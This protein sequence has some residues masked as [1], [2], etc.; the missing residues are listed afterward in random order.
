MGTTEGSSFYF[1]VDGDVDLVFKRGR[2]I[3]HMFCVKLATRQIL[4]DASY[5]MMCVQGCKRD[6]HNAAAYV[7]S[8]AMSKYGGKKFEKTIYLP[9]TITEDIIESVERNSTAAIV[10]GRGNDVFLIRGNEISVNTAMTML[11]E[12]VSEAKS[13]KDTQKP[14]KANKASR[15]LSTALNETLNKSHT[16][17]NFDNVSDAVKRA[18]A[19]CIMENKI[20]E[21][22]DEKDS[23]DKKK[24]DEKPDYI[25]IED[26][27]FEDKNGVIVI[28]DDDS[29]LMI[30]ETPRKSK[31]KSTDEKDDQVFFGETFESQVN[32]NDIETLTDAFGELKTPSKIGKSRA[33][34]RAA[35]DKPT[36]CVKPQNTGET[37][38]NDKSTVVQP[39]SKERT[40]PSVGTKKDRKMS[41]KARKLESEK[42][43]VVS[44]RK[45]SENA[46]SS[47]ASKL[48]KEAMNGS[49]GNTPKRRRLKT[50]ANVSEKESLISETKIEEKENISATDK[51]KQKDKAL[52]RDRRNREKRAKERNEKRRGQRSRRRKKS[53]DRIDSRGRTD[54]RGGKYSRNREDSRGRKDSR[55]SRNSRE[56]GNSKERKDSRRS[57]SPKES[58]ETRERSRTRASRWDRSRSRSDRSRNTSGQTNQPVHSYHTDSGQIN[59]P[60]LS[61]HNPPGQT[62]KP[63]LSYHTPRK[64]NLR[65]IVVDGSNVA[66]SHG[67]NSGVF[68]CRGIRLCVE[69][70]KTRGHD[71]ITVFLPHWRKCTPR[72]QNSV[73]HRHELDN[74]EKEG[75]L[76][77]TPSRRI[78][79]R[80]VA[81]YDD[82]FIIELAERE[83]G[84]VVSNDAYR[85]LRNEK[86]SWRQ[87][88]D[89]RLLMFS[90][91]HDHFMVPEDPLGRHGPSLSVFLQHPPD[92]PTGYPFRPVPPVQAAPV[93]L[94]KNTPLVIPPLITTNS[95]D[96]R[97]DLFSYHYNHT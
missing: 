77:Y 43:K 97:Q 6:Q 88:I 81:S 38:V 57:D 83:E 91:V 78:G 35:E 11:E 90:F 16:K 66:M 8:L 10:P 15:R 63:V 41:K 56:R 42:K 69:Y 85:D 22:T 60:V 71:L 89:N 46:G 9:P 54:S 13:K 74:L 58:T 55:W 21:E 40:E 53:R 25:L 7:Q 61:Y 1:M 30:I 96:A 2:R 86:Y 37:K 80:L 50:Q 95:M 62:N 31:S 39:V 32:E 5:H 64:N 52:S 51:V 75:Y 44:K 47:K 20:I 68:S 76:V 59:Q 45:L 27:S 23:D 79:K 94:I 19:S 14:A 67:R 48:L 84:V 29:E 33:T 70:F 65:Y 12:L 87:V 26:D 18:I 3:E 92:K 49:N 17:E 24:D 36:A 73:T 34:Q 72:D 82:R 28:D 93:P 4:K